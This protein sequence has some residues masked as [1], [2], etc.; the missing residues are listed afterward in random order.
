LLIVNAQPAF[1]GKTYDEA[2]GLLVAARD[3]VALTERAN[4]AR[5]EMSDRLRLCCET[6]RMT[7]RLTQVMAWLMA[8]KAI[9]AGEMSQRELVEKQGPLSHIKICMEPG[10]T[11]GLPSPLIGLLERSHNLYLRVARLDDRVRQQV[12]DNEKN[13]RADV[14]SS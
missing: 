10:P 6:M 13:D 5:L 8:Q 7:A 12:N 1:F 9:Y 3:Y 4:K 11:D 14:T 2:L